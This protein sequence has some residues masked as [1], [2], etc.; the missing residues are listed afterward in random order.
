MES[1]I[2]GRAYPYILCIDDDADD[3][4]LLSETLNEINPALIVHSYDTQCN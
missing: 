1:K 4:Q 2:A 3:L